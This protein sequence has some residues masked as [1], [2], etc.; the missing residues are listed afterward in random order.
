MENIAEAGDKV[1][2]IVL[3]A[4]F[5]PRPCKDAFFLKSMLEQQVINWPNFSTL[6]SVF[7]TG[8]LPDSGTSFTFFMLQPFGEAIYGVVSTRKGHHTLARHSTHVSL[9]LRWTVTVYGTITGHRISTK[10]PTVR[11]LISGLV[12]FLKKAI[13]WQII[14]S[15]SDSPSQTSLPALAF[16][17]RAVMESISLIMFLSVEGRIPQSLH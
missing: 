1:E 8:K 13:F 7:P 2:C 6:C 16:T 17:I 9:P 4:N 12:V 14:F 11:N 15:N 3:C 5:P 10:D